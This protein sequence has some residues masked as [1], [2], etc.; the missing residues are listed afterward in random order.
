MPTPR[1]VLLAVLLLAAL[2][3][4]APAADPPAPEGPGETASEPDERERERFLLRR[5]FGPDAPLRIGLTGGAAFLIGVKAG[6][7]VP[8]L[9]PR[10]RPLYSEI[11]GAGAVLGVE[12]EFVFRPALALVGR[13]AAE[14][15]PGRRRDEGFLG[16][17]RYSDLWMLP[18]QAGLRL[19]AP[20]ALPA[21]AWWV[22]GLAPPVTGACPFVE[23]LV[24]LSWRGAVDLEPLGRYWRPAWVFAAEGAAGLELRLGRLTVSVSAGFAYR[25]EPP[26]D[27]WYGE[28]E[29]AMAWAVRGAVSLRI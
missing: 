28:A 13:A 26:E 11:F 25:S 23:A 22:Q 15:F 21:S 19:Q 12:G 27:L 10:E 5:R 9:P 14:F 7:P 17:V 8:G 6:R 4:P 20:L 1:A 18:V 29:A 3:F 24:G 16:P 2:P